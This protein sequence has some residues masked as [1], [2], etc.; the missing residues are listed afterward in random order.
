MLYEEPISSTKHIYIID[1]SPTQCTPLPPI[2]FPIRPCHA[3]KHHVENSAPPRNSFKRSILNIY[4]QYNS[5]SLLFL[6]QPNKY[7]KLVPVVLRKDYKDRTK[8]PHTK[9]SPFPNLATSNSC[10]PM[11]IHQNTH[12][13]SYKHQDQPHQETNPWP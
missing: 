2:L 3:P 10:N 13:P 9:E 6:D 11:H 12:I 7:I 4:Y 8:T 1:N 5:T